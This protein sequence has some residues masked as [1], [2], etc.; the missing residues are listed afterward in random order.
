M[1]IYDG[2][3]GGFSTSESIKEKE[4]QAGKSWK[5]TGN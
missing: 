2:D 3:G 4:P 1:Q 5:R